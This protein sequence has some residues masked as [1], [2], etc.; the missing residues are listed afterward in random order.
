[1]DGDDA[2]DGFEADKDHRFFEAGGCAQV[3]VIGRIA[4]PEDFGNQI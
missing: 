3:P 1:M 4:D 2:Q